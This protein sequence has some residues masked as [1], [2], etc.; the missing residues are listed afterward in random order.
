VRSQTLGPPAMLRRENRLSLAPSGPR[1]APPSSLQTAMT[2]TLAAFAATLLT[3]VLL[4]VLWLGIVA[5]PVYR[6]GIGHLM[7]DEPKIPVAVVFYLVYAAGLVVFAV[8]PRA[9]DTRW[10]AVAGKGALFGFCAYATYDLT[11]LATL[12][13]WPASLAA[14]DMAWGTAISSVSATAG[15]LGVHRFGR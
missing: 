15:R 6:A 12:R 11:N 5:R 2:K 3:M 4:D 1:P 9:A 8:T 7:A 10:A 14:L 13:D